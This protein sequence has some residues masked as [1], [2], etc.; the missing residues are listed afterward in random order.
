MKI[1][2][3]TWRD[4]MLL[5]LSVFH[6]IAMI[7]L[8]I[9]WEQFTILGKLVSFVFLIILIVYNI[10]IISHL[11]T[12]TPWFTSQI[13]NRMVSLLNSIN[14]GQSIQAYHL[15]H[16][17][18]HH[19]YNNDQKGPD[20]KTQDR[21]STFQDGKNG[22]HASLWRYAF[23]G[24]VST[25][26]NIFKCEVLSM[27]RLW[28]VGKHEALLLMLVSRTADKRKQELKQVQWDRIAHFLGL[29]VFFMISW[30]WT[31]LCY[32][33]A[34][35]LSLAF[36]NVQNYYEHFG[37]LPENKMANSVSH[38][39]RVY[40][41]LTFN[42]GYHQEHHLSPIA[43]W[44]E[45]P[46]VRSTYSNQLDQVKRIISPLPAILGFLHRNRKQLHHLDR[47]SKQNFVELTQEKG[48]V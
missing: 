43:H 3:Y 21:S 46:K 45:M 14:I 40:N 44:C 30:Q 36:V 42:D 13:F 22:D 4:A 39:G 27:F 24:A 10:V 15:T 41:R 6:F 32:L 48:V 26:I 16:V 28:R 2:R 31:L 8:S 11:F 34:F 7:V 5:T 23:L 18:N 38:Y 9:E 35:Y 20:G 25:L 33:P 37:A 17:R 29:C 47:I 12:H 19:L 1:W